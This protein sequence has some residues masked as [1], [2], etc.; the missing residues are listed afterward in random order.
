MRDLKLLVTQVN[1]VHEFSNR[2][3]VMH[4]RFSC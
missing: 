3:S 4:Q 1:P 2:T